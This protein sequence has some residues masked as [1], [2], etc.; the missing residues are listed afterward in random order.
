MTWSAAFPTVTAAFLASL[1]E[2]VEAFTIILAVALTRGWKPA[3]LGAAVALALLVVIVLIFG[4]LLAL[5]PIEILQFTVGVLLILFGLR[6]LRKAILRASGWIA[7]H[8]EIAEFNKETQEMQALAA[9]R[10]ADWLGGLAVFKAVLL[11]GMDVI[12][13]THHGPMEVIFVHGASGLTSDSAKAHL[14]RMLQGH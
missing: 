6:W 11:E 3:W 1:V 8:D 5:V 7:L 10:K 4:P 2:V 14:Q 9:D 13:I 12:W